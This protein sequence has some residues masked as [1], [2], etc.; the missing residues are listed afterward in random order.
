[1]RLCFCLW[2]RCPDGLAQGVIRYAGG[3]GEDPPR[4]R[5]ALPFTIYFH[6]RPELTVCCLEK[7]GHMA[8]DDYHHGDLKSCFIC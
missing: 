4:L 6:D 7:H 5:L 1:M 8:S 3:L 2:V